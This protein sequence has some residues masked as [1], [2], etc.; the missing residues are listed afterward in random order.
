[1]SSKNKFVIDFVGIK[2]ND[3]RKIINSGNY[4]IN[5]KKLGK[6]EKKKKQN[7]KQ[8]FLICLTFI[9][10]FLKLSLRPCR[11]VQM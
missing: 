5:T 9:F 3:E 11:V 6:L 2:R 8:S 10:L 7:C 4:R 1:M